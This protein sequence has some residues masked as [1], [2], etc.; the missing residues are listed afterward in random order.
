MS[1]LIVLLSLICILKKCTKKQQIRQ[2]SIQ[3]E[4]E[5]YQYQSSNYCD[6]RYIY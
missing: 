5:K 2:T 1:V 6:I 4:D 3:L